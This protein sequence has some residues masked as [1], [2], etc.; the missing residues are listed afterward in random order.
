[1]IYPATL[2]ITILQNSTFELSLRALQNQKAITGFAV[3][4]SNPIFVVPCHRFSAGSKVVIVPQGQS[5]AS[6]PAA[7]P[8]TYDVPC[9]LELNKV[10]FVVDTGLTTNTF[11]ISETDGGSPI[12]VADTPLGSLMV[13]EPVD[14]TDYTADADLIDITTKEEVA[15][16]TCTLPAAADGLVQITMEPEITVD[17]TEGLNN[18]DLSLTSDTGARY[19]WL[20]GTATVTKTSSRS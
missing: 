12:T 9:G 16:F 8:E 17:L 3:A 18:W 11:T 2:N 19:Y 4:N 1:M 15:T 7:T 5:S 10:Y 13:A 14:L 20:Q 6:L